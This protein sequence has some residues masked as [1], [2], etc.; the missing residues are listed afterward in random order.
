MN[1]RVNETRGGLIVRYWTWRSD[2]ALLRCVEAEGLKTVSSKTVH[3]GIKALREIADRLED[4]N[5]AS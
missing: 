3:C 2:D 5:G 4:P 1:I